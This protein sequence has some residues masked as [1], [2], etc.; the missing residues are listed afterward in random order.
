MVSDIY[1]FTGKQILIAEDEETNYFYLETVLKR[2]G[3]VLFRA[4][5]GDEAVKVCEDQPELDLVLMDIKMPDMNGL[6]ATRMIRK[7]NSTIP[8]IA[9]TAYALVGE[10]NKCLNAGCNDYISKPINRESLLK[11]ISSFIG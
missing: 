11:M 2:T 7:F 10:R 1:N 4:K 5:N 3:A 9:Q 6:D 8:I